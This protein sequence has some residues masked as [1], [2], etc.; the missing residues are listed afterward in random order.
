MPAVIICPS[1]Q[2]WLKA[3]EAT[4][5]KTVQCPKCKSKVIAKAAANIPARP[6]DPAAAIKPSAIQQ[7]LPDSCGLDP[8]T[9]CKQT[10]LKPNPWLTAIVLPALIGT[11]RLAP[12]TISCGHAGSP[13]IPGRWTVDSWS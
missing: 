5:G 12:A 7:E 2:A 6:A 3:P 1:C 4:V 13:K 9:N 11:A 10:A 8:K